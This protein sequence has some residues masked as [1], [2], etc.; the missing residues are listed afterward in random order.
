MFHIGPTFFSS[1]VAPPGPSYFV[2]TPGS[3]EYIPGSTYLGGV[4]LRLTDTKAICVYLS[5]PTGY[6]AVVIT[7]SGSLP[8]FGAEVFVGGGSSVTAQIAAAVL[9]S[10]KVVI[11]YGDGGAVASIRAQVLNIAGDVVTVGASTYVVD[12]NNCFGVRADTLD[13][14][15]AICTYF[16]GG[17]IYSAA[18]S[19]SGDVVTP[20]TPVLVTSSAGGIARISAVSNATAPLWYQAAGTSDG[21]GKV[22]AVGG[23]VVTAPGLAYAVTSANTP[24]YPAVT[25]IGK[26]GLLW[27]DAS[28]NLQGTVATVSGD[29]ISYGGDTLQALAAVAGTVYDNAKV[30]TGYMLRTAVLTGQVVVQ[31]HA[32]FGG[33]T[34]AS[35]IEQLSSAGSLYPIAVGLT[36]SL[37]IVVWHDTAAEE[38]TAMVVA[39]AP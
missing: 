5:S 28:N 35:D 12:A 39:I 23:T 34:P 10:T 32:A 37:A 18:V 13:S 3:E 6:S 14:G 4:L 30:G 2:L 27:Y 8:V 26:V 24:V 19:V 22:L 9:S 7:E 16:R 15:R 33:V 17:D 31:L 21:S 29:V 1:E 25:N 38:L 20:G 36:S 11:F